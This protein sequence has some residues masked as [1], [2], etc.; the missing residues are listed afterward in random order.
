M[1][2]RD[3]ELGAVDVANADPGDE[4]FVDERRECTGGR[5]QRD[6]RIGRVQ[7]VQIDRHA[8]EGVETRLAVRS[9]RPR[10]AVGNPGAAGPRHAALRH[11]ARAGDV[12]E[13]PGDER[14]V[15]VRPSGVEHGDAGLRCGG[16]RGEGVLLVRG[17]P[18]APEPDA[19]LVA[20]AAKASGSPVRAQ[21]RL[22]PRRLVL[23]LASGSAGQRCEGPHA[24]AP[25]LE[26]PRP[27]DEAVDEERRGDLAS[28]DHRRAGARPRCTRRRSSWPRT[29]LSKRGSRRAGGVYVRRR[30]RRSREVEELALV[31]VA[32]APQLELPPTHGRRRSVAM[33]VHFATSARD[34]G[35]KAAR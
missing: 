17:Q 30:K 26:R 28:L 7:E 23:D 34:A 31:L 33:P 10:S 14:L 22:E 1:L 20:P 32:E 12:P 19:E 15:P 21:E 24:H 29:R 3:V 2:Q 9:D 18:H 4:A 6:A 11:D 27:C 8:V 13:C 5:R 35:P 16:D 25:V